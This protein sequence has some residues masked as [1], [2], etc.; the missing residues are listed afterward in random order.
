MPLINNSFI[1]SKNINASNIDL[2]SVLMTLYQK[3]IK[4]GEFFSK[5]LDSIVKEL[6]SDGRL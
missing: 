2:I 1:D 6:E 5:L 4:K 3:E